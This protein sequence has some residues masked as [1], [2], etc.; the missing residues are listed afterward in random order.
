M[1]HSQS[2]TGVPVTVRLY[3]EQP[4]RLH[5][6]TWGHGSSTSPSRCTTGSATST[7]SRATATRSARCESFDVTSDGTVDIDF[8]HVTENPLVNGIEIIRQGT[9]GGGGGGFTAADDV[10]RR[11]FTGTTVG[12]SGLVTP[13]TAAWSQTRGA[14]LVDGT[15]YTGWSDGTFARRTFNG[16]TF[17]DPTT[18]PSYGNSF[19]SEVPNLTG[20]VYAQGRIYYTLFGQSQLFWRWFSPESHVVGATPFTVGGDVGDLA[21]SRVQGMFLSGST[22]YAADRSSG[23]LVRVGLSGTTVTGPV[24]TV[25][26][27]N[28]WQ[29]R[30]VF[31]WNGG[32]APPPNVAPTAV[33]TGSCTGLTCTFGSAGS[34]DPDG[35]IVSRTWVFSDG[36]TASGA[37][38]THNFASGGD[39]TA[40]LTVTDDDGASDTD[41]V[42]V[43]AVAPPEQD[44]VAAFTQSCTALSC[45][46]DGTGSNDPDGG[47]IVSYAWDFAGRPE[48][49]PPRRTPS[50]L[51]ARTP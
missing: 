50:R 22:L 32:A 37:S 43:T 18:I 40:T 8:G 25:D 45:T 26:T 21:P 30:G 20:I 2:L 42:T 9:G 7:S 33:A 1:A 13:T 47:A 31:L 27:A 16:T 49:A 11:Y 41:V 19:A 17:G 51:R 36:G 38:P 35:S 3:L 12:S 5:Q 24:V 28:D 39:W 46:F 6:R 10:Q 14:F 29:G 15:L 44:P 34:S 23:D 48:S 4:V